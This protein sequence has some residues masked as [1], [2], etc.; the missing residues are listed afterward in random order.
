MNWFGPSNRTLKNQRT[1]LIN[2]FFMYTLHLIKG[3]TIWGLTN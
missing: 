2:F 3:F 1:P